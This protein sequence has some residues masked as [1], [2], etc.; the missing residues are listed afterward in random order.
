MVAVQ[1]SVVLVDDPNETLLAGTQTELGLVDL[2]DPGVATPPVHVKATR[3]FGTGAAHLLVNR[4]Q[5]LSILRPRSKTPEFIACVL[6]DPVIV[7]SVQLIMKMVDGCAGHA[8][9][10]VRA[11]AEAPHHG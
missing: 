1:T 9:V 11:P 2:I 7:L 5:E 8:V 3:T 6:V 10:A 4:G